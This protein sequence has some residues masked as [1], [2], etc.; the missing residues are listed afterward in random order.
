RMR[1]AR[2]VAEG[3]VDVADVH[4]DGEAEQQQLDRRD[5]QDHAEGEPVAAELA[6][7][8]HHDRKQPVGAHASSSPRACRAA[9]VAATN[10]SSR[11]G[12][13]ASIFVCAPAGN[14]ARKALSSTPG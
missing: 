3:G 14:S 8:L 13:A 5:A 9:C 6:Q 10:T 11:L 2:L 4:V 1:S 7:L 12:S